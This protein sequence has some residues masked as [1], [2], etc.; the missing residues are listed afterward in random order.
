[1]SYPYKPE[2]K[3]DVHTHTTLS[4]E[5]YKSLE[6]F[7]SYDKFIRVKAHKAK[8]C[9]A[10]MVNSR[11][12]VF[13]EIES[14]AYDGKSRV[15]DCNKHNI[16]MQVISPTPAMIP[17]YVDNKQDAADI[18]KIIND[19]NANLVAS[20]PG[21]FT[22][23]GAIPMQFPDAAINELERIHSHLGMR[24]IEI[25]SNIDGIE[26]D[27]PALFDI[28][29]AAAFMGIAVFIHPWSGFMNPSEENDCIRLNA[30]WRCT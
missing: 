26:L 27:D 30:L 11:G 9:C 5:T 25:N 15:E 17:D 10:C 23:L 2:E 20:H 22:A 4:P 24:G 28:F 18:C 7:T 16:T 29:E 21:R 19:D 14:N 8:P 6:R 1:L 3:W 13:R 12:E